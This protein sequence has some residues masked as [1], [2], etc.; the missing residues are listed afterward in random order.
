MK[1]DPIQYR[2]TIVDN[3]LVSSATL[4]LG[5]GRR[6]LHRGSMTADESTLNSFTA[7]IP[8]QTEGNTVVYYIEAG[9]NDNIVT[10]PPEAPDNVYS[11]SVLLDGIKAYTPGDADGS[12]SVDVFDLLNILQILSGTTEAGSGA[13]ANEDGKCERFRSADPAS[14]TGRRVE[15]PIKKGRRL[16]RPP[17][18]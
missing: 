16:N 1:P 15:S 3:V 11:F 5:T 18:L 9:D 14:D 4:Y 10:D 6:Q 2:P 17:F 7:E 13:D 8:G 12:G